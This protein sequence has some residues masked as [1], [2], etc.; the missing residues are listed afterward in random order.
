MDR[1]TALQGSRLVHRR[2]GHHRRGQR[3][4]LHPRC[5]DRPSDGHP[6]ILGIAAVALA[7]GT[8]GTTLLSRRLRTRAWGSNRAEIGGNLVAGP[9]RG[10]LRGGRR[11]SIGIAEDGH[12]TGSVMTRTRRGLLGGW[13]ESCGP[14]ARSETRTPA[15]GTGPAGTRG[16]TSMTKAR[17]ANDG[18]RLS[19]DHDRG[20]KGGAGSKETRLGTHGHGTGQTSE[21]LGAANWSAVGALST[22]LRDQRHEFAN[23]LHAVSGLLNVG[24]PE[25]AASY[26]QETLK[27]GPL[28]YPVDFDGRLQDT[29]LQGIHRREGTARGRGRGT[30]CDWAN[31]PSSP[32]PLPIR[33]TSPQ[34]SETS[35][36]MPSPRLSGAPVGNAGWKWNCSVKAGTLYI[37]VADS[38][39]GLQT[40]DPEAPFTE[41]YS[42]V[43]RRRPSGACMGN[44]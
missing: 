30:A 16:Q 10:A 3:R 29:Y 6:P 28:K 9:G 43:P 24:R 13:E 20:P 26:L 35:W 5:T 39:D 14:H 32:G 11:R 27:S 40:R 21:A 37:T 42:D 8:A 38:G 12:V 34:S 31:Q 18:E 22:A 41:G 1:P 25:E 15:A 2:T 23:R 7:L 4:V 44:K 36:T 19:T 33:K 17:R